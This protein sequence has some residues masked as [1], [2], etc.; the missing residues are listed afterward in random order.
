MKKGNHDLYNELV[1]IAGSKFVIDDDFAL[2]SYSKDSSPIPGKIPGI[3]V[4]PG[5]IDEVSEILKL[6][7]VTKTPVIPRGGGASIFGVP[8]GIPGRSIVIDLTRLNKIINID[9]ENMT[10]TAECG[11]TVAELGTNL[12]KKGYYANLVLMPYYSDTLGG[13]LSGVFG[14]GGSLRF[15]KTGTNWKYVV[16]LKVALPDGNIIQTGGGPGTNIHLSSTFDRAPGSPDITGMFIGDSGIFGVKLEATLQ[17]FPMEKFTI[18]GGFFFE[19]LEDMWDSISKLMGIKPTPYTS[20]VGFDPRGTSLLTQ[21]EEGY[22]WSIIYSVKG[23]SDNEVNF[24]NEIIKNVCKESKG[25]P[26]SE[27]INLA[28]QGL[29]DGKVLR[30]MGNYVSLGMWIWYESLAAKS[31]ALNHF[32][33]CRILIDR[34]FHEKRLDRYRAM[35]FDMIFPSDHNACYVSTDILWDDNYQEANKLIMEIADEYNNFIAENGAFPGVH[36]RHT[37]NS[38][39]SHWSPNFYDFMKTLKNAIDPNGILNPGLWRL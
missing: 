5:S 38:M 26:G 23:Y 19:T 30:D 28:A 34:R 33:R 37:D 36:Q 9:E 29:N 20:L 15:M 8:P 22:K 21:G 2:W 39:A 12:N 27:P 31:D 10:V 1:S 25:T 7:N 17:I 4:R 14:G 6:A 32:K 16:G 35:R 18:C 13:L 24:N 11:I 3:I